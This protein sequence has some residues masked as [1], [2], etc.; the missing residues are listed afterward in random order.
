MVDMTAISPDL[1]PRGIVSVLAALATLFL[2]GCSATQADVGQPPSSAAPAPTLTGDLAF[3][4]TLQAERKVEIQLTGA[5]E[6]GWRVTSALLESGYFVALPAEEHS[7]RLF[8]GWTARVPVPLGEATCPEGAETARVTLTLEDPEGGTAVA[9]VA[10]ATETLAL[11]NAT[12]CAA[13]AV[14]DVAAPAWG[15]PDASRGTSVETTLTLRREGKGG[16]PVAVTG[17]VGSVIFDV[18]PREGATF[19]ATLAADERELTVPVT[20]TAT[21]CDPH[22]FAESKKTFVFGVWIAVDAQEPTFVELHAKGDLKD[23]LQVAFDAC[24]AG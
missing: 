13:R 23:A 5:T 9:T 4:R 18:T 22:A 10:L 11:I 21:R 12:E 2:G 1:E 7:A 6:E 24:G 16:L 19:P 8:E 20:I 14:T 3:P 15:A 17:A